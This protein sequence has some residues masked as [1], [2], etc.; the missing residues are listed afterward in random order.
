MT[1][2]EFELDTVYSG[3][4]EQTKPLQPLVRLHS[5]SLSP[6]SSPCKSSDNHSQRKFQTKIEGF[7][8][9]V[10]GWAPGAALKHSLG[11]SDRRAP[12][13]DI[14][15]TAAVA[16]GR[17]GLLEEKVLPLL[18]Y[19]FSSRVKK[20]WKLCKLWELRTD[21]FPLWNDILDRVSQNLLQTNAVLIAQLNSAAIC[22]LQIESCAKQ[23]IYID[24]LSR[25]RE[26]AK[27]L[28]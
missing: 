9:K 20:F 18:L 28:I 11:W 1:L 21:F 17:T 4:L 6:R 13:Q 27:T 22:I 25:K 26:F 8:C 16:A 19:W 10:S 7:S 3:I 12:T 14:S 2:K 24:W 15:E 23:Q 5:S